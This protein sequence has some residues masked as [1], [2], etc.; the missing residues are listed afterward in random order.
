M[1]KF[2]YGVLCAILLATSYWAGAR[3]ND[4]QAVITGPRPAE[5]AS[6]GAEMAPE[7]GN[8]LG[9]VDTSS[10]APGT[11][12]ISPAMQQMI[13]VSTGVAKKEERAATLRLLGSVA[14]DEERVFT[15][16]AGGDGIIQKVFPGT[17]GSLVKEGQPLA[18]YYSPDLFAAEQ[19]LV[20]VSSDR[21][22]SSLQELVNENKLQFLGLTPSQI[23]ELKKNHEVDEVITLRAPGAGFVLARK[24][25]PEFRFQKG[26]ELYR[27]VDLKKV[28]IYADVYASEG[29]YLKPHVKATVSFPQL[30]KKLQAEV[31]D[32]LPLFDQT[33]R[34][35]KVR[36]EV[37]NPEILLRPDMFVDVELPITL[38]LAIT[39]PAD[40]VLD[41]G[42]KKI[43]FIDRGQGLFE[44]REVEIGWYFDNHV[45][46]SGGLEPGERVALS[47]TFLIDSE[48]KMELAAAGM[49]E[50]MSKD[51]VN[52]MDVSVNKAK[53]AGLKSSFK[54]KTYYFS[55]AES[56]EQFDKGPENYLQ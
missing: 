9:D 3:H 35:L 23:K 13:G 54:G 28:W 19:Y 27:I 26:E 45:E 52:D 34:T 40:A 47:S 4:R 8:E 50:T 49:Y 38:P 21:Y 20:A 5:S 22:R 44:P 18:T 29:R 37:D 41:S 55:S 46:I 42:L 12:R 14:V 16:R 1:K 15:V 24:V 30:G 10:L 39:L 6:S 32:V 17:T 43:V 11:V 31:S 2:L 7:G 51:P 53:T 56:K 48:S 25:S 36:L 33:T